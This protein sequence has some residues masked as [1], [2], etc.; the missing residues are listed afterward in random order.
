MNI[1]QSHEYL[2]RL[3]LWAGESE[4]P[5]SEL[6][7]TYGNT[8]FATK[9]RLALALEAFNQAMLDAANADLAR[10]KSTITR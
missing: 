3:R 10:I 6:H 9:I 7:N 8:L 2:R 4:T 1:E 5:E